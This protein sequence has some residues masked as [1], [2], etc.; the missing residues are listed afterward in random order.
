MTLEMGRGGEGKGPLTQRNNISLVRFEE[1]TSGCC[2]ADIKLREAQCFSGP[3]YPICV[4]ELNALTKPVLKSQL[5]CWESF[6]S[7]ISTL[8]G[9]YTEGKMFSAS[10]CTLSRCGHRR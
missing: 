5:R 8:M 7:R 6:L 1:T 3:A 9:V 4:P 10:G 2:Y